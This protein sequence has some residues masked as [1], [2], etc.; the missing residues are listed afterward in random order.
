MN[1]ILIGKTAVQIRLGGE[2]M[3][4]PNT[5][6]RL[7][8]YYDPAPAPDETLNILFPSSTNHVGT[9]GFGYTFWEIY[10]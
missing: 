3:V 1:F 10:S 6:I 4:S 5:A 9:A 2:Y 7:G 8:Y